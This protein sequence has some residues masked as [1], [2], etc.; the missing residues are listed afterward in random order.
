MSKR[1]AKRKLSNKSMAVLAMLQTGYEDLDLIARSVGISVDEVKAIENADDIR[2]RR[3]LTE[4]LPEN[5]LY[6]IRLAVKCTSCG[7]RINL[8]PCVLCHAT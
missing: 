3:I 7:S 6:R 1:Q 5:F 2:V 8:V 4:G